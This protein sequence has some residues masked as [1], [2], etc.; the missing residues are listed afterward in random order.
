MNL[1]LGVFNCM[2]LVTLLLTARKLNS[3]ACYFTYDCQQDGVWQRCV[4][5]GKLEI[6]TEKFSFLKMIHNKA[7]YTAIQS[8]TVGQEQ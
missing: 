8:R 1:G 4:K 2:V 3:L 6:P 7:G 5:G